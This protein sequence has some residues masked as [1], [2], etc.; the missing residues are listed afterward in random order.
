MAFQ[1]QPNLSH[2]KVLDLFAGSGG[3]SLGFRNAGFKPGVMIDSCPQAVETL[4]KNF[5]RHKPIILKEDLAKFRPLD[6]KKAL[7]G[8]EINIKEIDIIIGGPPCQ[9]W[10][11][12]GRGKLKSLGRKPKD[13][14]RNRLYKRFIDYVKALQPVVCLMEN[15]PG[16]TSIGGENIAERVKKDIEKQGYE[17][18][19]E[20]L[21]AADYGVPQKRKRLFFIGIREDMKKKKFSMPKK[22]KKTVT[23]RDAIGDLPE[24]KS[25]APKQWVMPYNPDPG[26][27]SAYS[28]RLG[29]GRGK[30]T[31]EDH[32]CRAH[33]AQDIEAFGLMKEGGWYRDLPKKYK[34]YRDDI[35]KD[36]YKKLRWSEPS[37]CVT[38]HLAKDCY[39]HIHPEQKRTISVREA[40][41]LQSF[42]DSF[43][44]GFDGSGMSPK[45]RLIGNAVP[46]LMAEAIA[47]EIKKQVF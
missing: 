15:V 22:A 37:G 3:L 18:T 5:K 17:V 27:Q 11:L 38:A 41:R 13:D 26:R 46:P 29:R 16:M 6:F 31:I 12:T 32:V 2:I 8:K 28:K 36:K 35:F 1:T 7:L 23:V 24:I 45:F 9:G 25:G 47:K 30:N 44:F 4:S 40:A 21:N 19:F 20:P 34:R 10:S 14:P 39:T 43:L 42:P 33:N